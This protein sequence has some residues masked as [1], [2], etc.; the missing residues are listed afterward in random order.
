M[1]IYFD[2]GSVLLLVISVGGDI[3]NDFVFVFYS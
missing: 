1:V 2:V 3:L